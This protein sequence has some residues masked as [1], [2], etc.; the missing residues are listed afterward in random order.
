MN[1]ADLAV[2]SKRLEQLSMNLSGEELRVS[3]GELPLHFVERREYLPASR[4]TGWSWLGLS[5]GW[6]AFRPACKPK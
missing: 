6:L 4:R 3:K 1:L 2:R 5:I